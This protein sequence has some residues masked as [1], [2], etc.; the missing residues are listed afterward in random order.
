MKRLTVATVFLILAGIIAAAGAAE[1]STALL[2]IRLN[3]EISYRD[4]IQRN[5][6]VLAVYP[7]G[8]ADIAVNDS[9]R[10]WIDSESSGYQVL[11]QQGMPRASAEL[12]INLGNYHTYA[13][14]EM[15][16]DSLAN[17]FPQIT[18]LDTLGTSVEGRLIRGIKISDNAGVD[19][20]EP[21]VLIMGCHHAREL[22]SVEVPLLLAEYLLDG[23]GESSRLTGLVDG[24]EIWIVPMVNPD[25]HVYVQFNHSGESYNWWRKNRRDNLDGTYG[26]DLNR[27]YSYKWG[28]DDT[29]SSPNTGSVVYRGPAPFSEPE[30][31]AVR[32][33]CAE[34]SFS[35]ALSYHSYSEL[36][37]YPWG[38]SPIYTEDH[39]FFSTFADSLERGNGY[40]PGCS[41]TGA[42]Y[43]TNGDT[44]DWAYG[45]TTE[46]DRFY[47]FT[48]ELNSYQEGGFAPPDTLIQPTF[49]KVLELNLTLIGRAD[50]PFSVMGPE[51]PVLSDV[52]PLANPDFLLEWS[53]PVPS[54]PNQPSG[55]TITEYRGL[56][57]TR[58]LCE[59]GDTLWNTSG[60]YLSDSRSSAGTHSFYSGMGSSMNNYLEMETVYPR[61]LG[62]TL[63]CQVWYDIETDW[64]YAYLEA[65]LDRGLTYTTVPGNITTSYDPRGNNRGNGITGNSGG[66]VQAGFY[67]CDIPGITPDAVIDLRFAYITDSYIEEEGIYV[68]DVSPTAYCEQK[69]LLAESVR[70]TFHVVEP[71]ETGDYAYQVK[72]FDSE[73]HLSRGSNIV[74]HSVSDITG[75]TPEPDYITELRQNYPNPFNPVTTIE[76]TVGGT[77]PAPVTLEVFDVSGRRVASILDRSMT[78][79][80]HSVRWDGTGDGGLK[81]ASGIYF[82]RLS[83]SGQAVSKKMVLLK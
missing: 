12:D 29:G 19:E 82:M 55:Y 54:G 15:A 38:Y 3:R 41:A 25:G 46:K 27:N 22:M 9:Q 58:D 34:H 59:P 4:L 18:R 43:P 24:R 70:D 51:V 39:E 63:R 10:R 36:I 47:C 66:W 61:I 68:D 83:V 16:L 23:Y 48:V 50:E 72:A 52:T 69:R 78:P 8:K 26:V 73:G 17:N 7:D 79:G 11:H 75:D 76:F 67:I 5:I 53:G 20:D 35:V 14:M 74:F 21:E 33:F 77:I 1:D 56:A 62:D 13:E 44:D 6:D 60:F 45:E 65:S 28:Y 64:D 81:L 2:R 32:D 71:S 57:G 80:R 37:L 31:Q 40:L 30:T 42:I 49:D